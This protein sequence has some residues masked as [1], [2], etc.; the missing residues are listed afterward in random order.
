VPLNI[1]ELQ[2]E[3]EETVAK[4]KTTR[5]PFLRREVLKEE[6]LKEMTRLLNEADRA[7]GP[8]REGMMH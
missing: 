7:L 8:A 6:V 4:P 1:A 5:D 2:R 3:I